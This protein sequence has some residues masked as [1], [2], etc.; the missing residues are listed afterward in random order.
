MEMNQDAINMCME[1]MLGISLHS[2]VYL[3]LAQTL[4]LS[5]Y[6]FCFLFNK[7][8]NKKAAQVLPRSMVGDGTGRE[9][10]WPK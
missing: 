2:Y 5:Y 8:E 7:I 3:K 9:G 4:C 6:L 10:R 1:A